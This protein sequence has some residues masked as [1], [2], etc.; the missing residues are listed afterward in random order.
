MSTT[1]HGHSNRRKSA[2]I[3]G[4]ALIIMALAA[5]FSYGFVH[6]NL[7]LQGDA[8]AIFN[9]LT[10][11]TM[12]FKAEIFGWM[13]ILIADIVVTWAFYTFLEPINRNLALL[14]AWL[15]LT[16]TTILGVAILNLVFVLLLSN[17][18]GNF[19]FNIDQL[20][21]HVMLFLEAFETIWAI[22]LIIFGGHLMVI[23]YIACKSSEIPKVIS[24]L[25]LLAAIGYIII[26]VFIVFFSQYDEVISILKLIF[27]VP[28]IL[29]ELGFGIWLL[30]RG[31]KVS[32]AI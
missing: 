29:G 11:S 7:V 5:F 20:Q 12:L 19:S 28:M 10:S 30:I 23:G 17:G 15:R 26:N 13:I 2:L 32:K 9:N 21:S 25:L 1:I 16:Y 31:G 14:A 22:D 6:E 8:S 3:G 4:T 27:N 24:I 18:I